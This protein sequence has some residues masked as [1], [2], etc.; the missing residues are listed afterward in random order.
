MWSSK[1]STCAVLSLVNVTSLI[2]R[3][4]PQPAVE[5]E[6]ALKDAE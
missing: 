3:P 4:R 1:K 6:L 5:M 2:P